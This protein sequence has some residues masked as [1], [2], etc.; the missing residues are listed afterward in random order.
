M[1]PQILLL[2]AGTLAIGGNLTLGKNAFAKR[3]TLQAEHAAA[4]A[5][6][7]EY[8]AKVA[9]LPGLRAQADDARADLLEL[10]RRFPATENLGA[11]IENIQQRATDRGLEIESVTRTVAPSPVPGF[12][13][14]QLN[15]AAT[16]KYP[17]L[18]SFLRWARDEPRF[19]NVTH[20]TSSSD[21]TQ[22]VKLTGY[23][24]RQ[25]APE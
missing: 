11:L 20:I 8:A 16:G 19:L 25:G 14:V 9:R 4:R 24:R 17:A 13:E 22:N 15:L 23:V 5:E 6:Y 12:D 7:D 1:N 3:Q 2:L 10:T 21:G 18:E